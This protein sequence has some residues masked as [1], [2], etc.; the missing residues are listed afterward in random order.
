M[1]GKVTCIVCKKDLENIDNENNGMQPSKGLAFQTQ[2]HY[3]TTVFDPMDGSTLE[4]TVCDPCMTDAR[5]AGIVSHHVS[6]EKKAKN[7]KK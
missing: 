5:K 3:G 6:G 4:I 7:W 1:C 2:G